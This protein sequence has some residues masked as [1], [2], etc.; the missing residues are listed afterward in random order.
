MSSQ[1]A[2]LPY[3]LTAMILLALSL[4]LFGPARADTPLPAPQGPVVLRVFG[5]VSVTNSAGEAQFDLAMLQEMPDTMYETTTLWTNGLQ[6][7]RGVLL[8]ELVDRLKIEAG[9]LEASALNE[10]LIEIP[11]EDAIEGG[12]LIAYERNGKP[13]SVR[14]KGPLWMIYPYDRDEKF[15]SETYYA[16]SI[17]QMDLI[18]VLASDAAE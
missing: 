18:E 16:R 13:M 12:A 10:Y 9:T 4:T 15:R 11:L 3:T 5:D 6:Q 1:R 14:S 17:W 8:K 7:F 2:A